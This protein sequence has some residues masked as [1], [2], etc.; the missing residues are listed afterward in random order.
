[1]RFRQ[2]SANRILSRR[3]SVNF[4]NGQYK[5]AFTMKRRLLSIFLAVTML[6][7]ALPPIDLTAA[8]YSSIWCGSVIENCYNTAYVK[9][10]DS[11]IHI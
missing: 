6:L 1:M 2:K 4:P 8:E 9:T 11:F 10:D 5:E 7:L 3:K